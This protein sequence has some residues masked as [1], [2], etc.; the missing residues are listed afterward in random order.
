MTR[1]VKNTVMAVTMAGA[2]SRFANAGYLVPKYE[3]AAHGRTLFAWSM[4]SLRTFIDDGCR[5]VFVARSGENAE[6]FIAA[7]CTPLGIRH[8][9]IVTVDAL[10]D[11]QA[12][13]AMLA[14]SQI[15]DE[16]DPFAIY[17]IDTC[18][19]AQA[20]SIRDIRGQGWIPCFPGEG[21]KWSFAIADAA[22]RVSEVREKERVSAN[23]TLGL[24]W[25]D[26]FARYRNAYRRYY[27]AAGRQETPER[28]V[29]PIYNQL[30]AD[31][32]EVNIHY[33]PI[34]KVFPLGTP[35]DVW[36]FER[37]APGVQVTA[38]AQ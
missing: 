37:R 25:F 14:G 7:A 13:T 23:A 15:D 33:V 22:G 3:I 36:K 16:N 8:Y 35:G 9:R 1:P 11:G 18:V 17:N 4:E 6:D 38:G 20:M 12:T 34:G 30:I 32:A 19:E 27:A 21:N 29:A 10:T 28:Y 2:G 24:Y 5:F 26:S 31:G